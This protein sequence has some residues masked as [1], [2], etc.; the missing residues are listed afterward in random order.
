MV[1]RRPWDQCSFLAKPESYYILNEKMYAVPG[2]TVHILIPALRR[3]R[4]ADLWEF[5]VTLVYT[6]NSK[7]ARAT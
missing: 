7:P 6:M 4:Q 2:V 1:P 5:K 3:K